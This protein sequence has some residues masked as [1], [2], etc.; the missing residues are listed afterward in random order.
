MIDMEWIRRC[1]REQ[2][3]FFSRHGDRERRNDGLTLEE[4]EQ[5]IF[6]GRILEQYDDTGR[7]ASCL[8]VGFTHAGKPVHVVCGRWDEG[9]V[10]ITVTIP[11][12]PKFKTPFERGH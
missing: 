2:G 11:T 9:M 6:T 12:L 7:G 4:V 3:Y 10:I 8:V 5:A 1:V